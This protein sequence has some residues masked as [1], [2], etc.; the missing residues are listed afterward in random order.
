MR[1]TQVAL[2]LR[3]GWDTVDAAAYQAR[4]LRWLRGELQAADLSGVP[5]D[6]ADLIS[7]TT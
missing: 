4:E 1:A 5:A 3:D 7:L 6:A 2:R